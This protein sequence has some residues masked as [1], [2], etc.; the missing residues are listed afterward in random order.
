MQLPP[1]QTDPVPQLVKSVTAVHVPVAQEW[2]WP[3]AVLQQIPP[4][5]F[6]LVH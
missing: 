1:T 6:A 4:T 2:H 3:Q 5:Q